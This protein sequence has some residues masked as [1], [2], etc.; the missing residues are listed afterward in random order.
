M[1]EKESWKKDARR[2]DVKGGM[3][4]E[5]CWKK[6]DG[7]GMMEEGHWKGGVRRILEEG[8]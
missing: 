2:R 3:L 7:R 5:G 1:L 4:K 6:D 8:R